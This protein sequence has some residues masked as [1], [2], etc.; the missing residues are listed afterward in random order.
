ML[1]KVMHFQT[2]AILKEQKNETVNFLKCAPKF[3]MWK[4][5]WDK[6][7]RRILLC[8]TTSA[9]WS[10]CSWSGYIVFEFGFQLDSLLYSVHMYFTI[11]VL[12]YNVCKIWLV[13]D[14]AEHNYCISLRVTLCVRACVVLYVCVWKLMQ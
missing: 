14:L 4:V 1:A 5:P 2:Y 11:W 3:S 13:P 8:N 9:G 7:G 12:K 10:Y 6:G